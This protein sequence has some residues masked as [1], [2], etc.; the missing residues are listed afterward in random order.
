MNKRT[1]GRHKY[2]D[3]G[4]MAGIEVIPF[5]FLTLVV[6]ALLLLNAWAVVDAKLAVSAAAREGARAYVESSSEAE[7]VTSAEVAARSSIHGH[8]H[9]AEQLQV[10]IDTEGGFGRCTLVTI[11]A[12]LEVHS[13]HLPFVGGFGR[14]FTIRSSHHEVVDPYRSGLPGEADCG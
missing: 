3:S 11:Q 5:G 13:V 4:Q 14:R 2:D 8:G 12:T 6:G 7:A 10:M 1:G 9:D